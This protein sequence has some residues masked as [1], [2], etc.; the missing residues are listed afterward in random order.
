MNI[1]II[2]ETIFIFFFVGILAADFFSGFSVALLSGILLYFAGQNGHSFYQNIISIYNNA[3]I[4]EFYGL[5]AF[6]FVI[7][8]I[9]IINISAKKDKKDFREGKVFVEYSPFFI[10]INILFFGNMF[11]YIAYLFIFGALV[12]YEYDAMKNLAK[13]E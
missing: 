1:E 9:G 11:Y 7:F 10:L 4:E 2:L 6:L 12:F 8:V 3:G 13:K 5:F